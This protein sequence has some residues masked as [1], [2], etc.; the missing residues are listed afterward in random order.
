MKQ[1]LILWC[2]LWINVIAYGQERKVDQLNTFVEEVLQRFPQV[3]GL[4]LVVVNQDSVLLAKGYGLADVEKRLRADANTS[5]YIASCTKSFTALLATI[6]SEK[7]Q[8][9]FKKPLSTYAPFKNFKEKSHF[10]QVTVFD[11]LTHQSGLE[12]EWLSIPLAYSGLYTRESILHLLEHYTV[13]KKTGKQFEYTNDGYYLLSILLQEEF[14]LDWREALRE[15]VFAPLGM[16]HSS[17]YYSAVEPQQVAMPYLGILANH[18]E[19]AYLNKTDATMHAAGGIMAT[20]QDLGRWLMFQLN[21]GKIGGQQVYPAPWLQRTQQTYVANEHKYSAVFQGT[22][23]GLGWRMGTFKQT[24]VVY[25]FGGYPGFFSHISFLPEKNLGVALVVNH[26]QGSVIGNLIAEYAYDLYLGDGAALKQHKE[27]LRKKLPQLIQSTQDA[28]LKSQAKLAKREWLLS[29][30]Q[31][32]YTGQY[33]HPELGTIVVKQQN[34]TLE[35]TFGNMR[36]LATPYTLV[37]S[38]RLELIPGSGTVVQFQVQNQQVSALKYRG[39][40]F[41]KS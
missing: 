36:S 18:P 14:G 27:Y 12:N 7:G 38:I 37:E 1:G 3:P 22:G 19:R 13:P 39:M 24:P 31:A 40:T 35:L 29:L 10:D 2:L 9:D 23:Y 5:Y 34:N 32:A 21:E 41:S 26:D 33:V 8:L 25:H 16:Q 15:Q 30:P 17:A 20:A 11:L 6:L 4:N 28:E